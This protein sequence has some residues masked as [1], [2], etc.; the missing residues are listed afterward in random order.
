MTT[1]Q[2]DETDEI[3]FGTPGENN[4]LKGAGGDDLIYGADQFDVIDGGDGSDTIYGYEGDDMLDGEGGADVMFGGS[5][6]DSYYLDNR[7][8]LVRELA[9]EGHDAVYA[10]FSYKL[11][12]NVEDLH[13]TGSGAITGRGTAQ[14]NALY[15]NVNDNHLYGGAGDDTLYGLGGNDTMIG[16][17]GDDTY[18]ITEIGDQIVELGGQGIDTAYVSTENYVL[19]ARVALNVAILDRGYVAFTGNEQNTRIVGNDEANILRG[20]AGDDVLEGGSGDDVL[21]GGKGEDRLVGGAGHDTLTGG[22]GA[23]TFVFSMDDIETPT[24]FAPAFPSSVE[25]SSGDTIT[26]LQSIDV[27][28]LSG[29]DA[30]RGGDDDAFHIVDAFTGEAGELVITQVSDGFVVTGDIEGFGVANLTI[31][32]TTT[33]SAADFAGFIL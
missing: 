27:I 14:A 12:A 7:G 8:D 28:D 6:G 10:G 11:T 30:I 29:V 19:A 23:D 13:L 20:M 25:A 5:G 26:D 18:Y 21:D 33:V 31:H 3:I 9:D 17:A 4:L 15:G 32:V 1:H 22:I 2:G 24:A 16:G